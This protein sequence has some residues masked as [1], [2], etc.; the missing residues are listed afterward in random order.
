MDIAIGTI[1]AQSATR[2]NQL[3]TLLVHADHCDAK[4]IE[5]GRRVA[6]ETGQRLDLVLIQLG[7]VSERAMAEAYADLCAL[8]LAPPDR[9]P[10]EAPL[11][12]GKVKALFLSHA[13]AMPI[14][15]ANNTL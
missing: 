8:P 13:G 12:V 5:R 1:G 10:A 7:L 4:A 11:F 9:Y 6:A 15:L 2:L 14:A 3:A